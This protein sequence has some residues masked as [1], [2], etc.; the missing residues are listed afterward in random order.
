MAAVQNK[1]VELDEIDRKLINLIQL[2]FPVSAH[3]F[4]DIAAEIGTTEDVV[5]DKLSRLKKE[6]VIRRI[7]PIINT[8]GIGGTNTLAAV[9]VPENQID[10]A[11]AVIN[12]YDEVSHNYLRNEEYNIWFT[13]SA[14]TQDRLNQI[15]SEIQ[16]ELDCPLLDLPTIK[17]F[18]IQVNFHV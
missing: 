18:K 9:K 13:V 3:P 11:A 17:Q 10:K 4:E 6:G 8:R 2:N 15:L 14:P 5:I 7:G 16:T 12:R 1:P